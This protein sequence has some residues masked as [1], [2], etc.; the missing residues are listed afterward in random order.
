VS[1]VQLYLDL[2]QT[3]GRGEEAASVILEEVIK[4]KWR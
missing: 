3:K 2:A 1:P 4:A